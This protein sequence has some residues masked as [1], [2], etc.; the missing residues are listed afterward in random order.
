MDS[1]HEKEDCDLSEAL[2][3]ILRPRLTGDKAANH[4]TLD[5]LLD[6]WAD[7]ATEQCE[8]HGGSVRHFADISFDRVREF[9][10]VDQ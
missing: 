1:D 5:T 10:S 7:L 6:L 4:R 8:D 3:E 2:L 9:M